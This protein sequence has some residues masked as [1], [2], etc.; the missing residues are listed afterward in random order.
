MNSGPSL[1]SSQSPLRSLV[2]RSESVVNF[3]CKDKIQCLPLF[4]HGVWPQKTLWYVELYE[5]YAFSRQ[6]L[7][8]IVFYVHLYLEPFFSFDNIFRNHGAREIRIGLSTQQCNLDTWE[9]SSF[10]LA[11]LRWSN[12]NLQPAPIWSQWKGPT[13]LRL[14][15]VKRPESN[16]QYF[17]HVFPPVSAKSIQDTQRMEWNEAIE[18]VLLQFQ[19]ASPTA[20]DDGS[21]STTRDG[22]V[23]G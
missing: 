16:F 7:N 6:T 17:L 13:W 18:F 19:S 2:T 11:V 8:N 4:Q 15:S 10:S 22:W 23:L 9:T 5:F 12:D 3:S 14:V 21:I 20:R 1:P